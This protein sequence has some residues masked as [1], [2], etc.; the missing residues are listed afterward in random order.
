M[1]DRC[2]GKQRV[3][4]WGRLASLPLYPAGDFAP[5]AD[6]AITYRNHTAFESLLQRI[7]IGHVPLPVGMV[8]AKIMNALV[9]LAERQNAEK[10]VLFILTLR[11][12]LHRR[13]AVRV[14]QCGDDIG[15]EQPAF[16][17]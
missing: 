9:I 17:S 15:V 3:D 10:E 5:L 12:S 8:W 13:R 4:H 16:H 2:D 1:L 6:N 14:D 7:A 11:P